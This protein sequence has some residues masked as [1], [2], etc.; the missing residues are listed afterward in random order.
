MTLSEY[1]SNYLR[2]AQNRISELSV[3]MNTIEDQGSY[4][5]EELS[6]SRMEVALLMDMLYEGKW[7]IRKGTLEIVSMTEDDPC[8]VGVSDIGNLS[9]GDIVYIKNVVGMTEV[10]KTKFIARNI[11]ENTFELYDFNTDTPVD[12]TGYT[13]YTDGGVVTIGWYN[14]V[15]VGSDKTWT[16]WELISEIEHVRYYQDINEAPGVNFTGHYLKIASTIVGGGAGSGSLPAGQFGQI[17]WYNNSNNPEA[18]EYDIWAGQLSSEVISDYFS[19]R[20]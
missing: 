10:N 17:I 12:S 3:E 13:T 8:V 14:H 15:S 5:Y 4:K 19:G 20:T 9:E 1:I 11:Y 6:R 2:D 16:E 18:I 7:L